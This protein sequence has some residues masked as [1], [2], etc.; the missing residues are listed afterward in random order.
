MDFSHRAIEKKW[1]KYWEE[2]NIYKT[3]D[4]HDKK[5]YILDMFP[6]PSGAGLHVGHVKGYTATD[7]IARYKR[8][9]GFDVLHP[10]GYDAF[11]LPAEQ[12]ALKTG[13][14]PREFTLKNIDVFREQLKKL[15][16][17][18]D[19]D[20]E[21]TTS[22]PN[23]YKITQWIFEQFYKHGLA[24]IRYATVNWCPGLGTVLANEEVEIKNGQMVSE[25]GGFPVEKKPMKQWVLLITKY[26]EKLL[27][28]LDNTQFPESVKELQRNW[29]G[30]SEGM[31]VEFKIEKGDDLKVFTT[32]PDTIYGVTYLVLAPE[33]GIVP[34]I[35]TKEH[36]KE[37]L[38]YIDATSRKSDLERK[39]ESQPK[40]GAFTGSYAIHPLT[41]EKLP[42]WISDY[43]LN[44]YGSGAVMGVPAHDP[45]DWD[46]ATKFDLPIKF[47]MET[48]TQDKVFTG[49]SKMINSG[50]LDGLTPKDAMKKIKDILVK[51]GIGEPKVN[52][53]LRDWLFSRQR[54]YGE[55]FPVLF[56]EQ[57]NIVL[58]PEQDL[59]V[60]LPHGDY[61]K[62]SGTGESPLANFKDWVNVDLDG[63]KYRRETN[64]MPQWAAS[65]W[66]FLAYIL[67]DKPNQLIDINSPEAM[68]RFKK[69]MPVDLYVGGQEHAVT[70]LLYSRFW[71]QFLFDIGIVPYSE[72]Y[73]K[74]INQGMILGPDGE[75]MS[76]SKGNTISPDEIVETHGA[77]TLRLYEMFMGPIDASLPWSYEGLDGSMKWLNR[78]YRLIDTQTFTDTNNGHLDYIYNE[79]VK[80]VTSMIE[81]LKFNTAISQLMVLVNAMY[82]EEENTI[83]KP[84]VEGLIKMLSLFAPY[85]SEEM[86]AMLG[87]KPSVTQQQWPTFDPT[88]LVLT[89]TTV[90]FQVNGKVRGK[91]EVNKGLS[92]EELLSLAKDDDNVKANLEGKTIVKEIVVPDKIVNIV[93][94]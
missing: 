81:D 47:V 80:K 69:W 38:D 21:V 24:E 61:I 73:Q 86:W 83:Y 4:T 94:K 58:V 85:I 66:Y 40:T 18:Y 12:Y 17:S 75:K 54:F 22:D 50:E 13:N 34:E 90:V 36:T 9:N 27:D 31:E 30:K 76:K 70:H 43:V 91:A 2:N 29:I 71:N 57:G 79:V 48:K 7:I 20:K 1:R 15:G 25:V 8:M 93:A 32:R 82:K 5:A 64:T 56:D 10:I 51:K 88:K 60:K 6:Y 37:V 35:T 33:N 84:Y 39:D 16:F 89:T 28:G 53:R 72:P 23:F 26:A 42:I 11:G 92:K 46:F 44:D 68:E 59:P 52:Y 45:R 74:L 65:S 3:T 41:G 67:T 19:Y 63:V 14:D 87:N 77:D 78:V 55:P 49:K 62:P